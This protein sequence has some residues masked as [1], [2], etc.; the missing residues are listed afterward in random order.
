MD[1]SILTYTNEKTEEMYFRPHHSVSVI[2]DVAIRPTIHMQQPVRGDFTVYR[3]SPGSWKCIADFE[4]KK[5]CIHARD[6]TGSNR[7][8]CGETFSQMRILNYCHNLFDATSSTASLEFG[9][10]RDFCG[11]LGEPISKEFNISCCLKTTQIWGP[12]ATCRR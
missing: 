5:K 11:P 8:F 3:L 1:T 4:R 10:P 9:S 2:S 12:H 7:I 6:L